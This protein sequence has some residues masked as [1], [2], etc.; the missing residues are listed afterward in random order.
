MPADHLAAGP[1]PR[2]GSGDTVGNSTYGRNFVQSA[3]STF[4]LVVDVGEWDSSPAPTGRPVP[5][6][7]GGQSS[8]GRTPP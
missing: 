1:E 2:G 8:W 5:P 6:G 7:P 3:G 4:R